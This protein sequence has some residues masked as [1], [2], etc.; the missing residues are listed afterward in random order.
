MLRYV[1]I[2]AAG[3]VQQADGQIAEPLTLK[4]LEVQPGMMM[5]AARMCGYSYVDRLE[6]NWQR[7][8]ARAPSK[9]LADQAVAAYRT[10]FDGNG[11][12][13]GEKRARI[14]SEPEALQFRGVEDWR[15][16]LE[17]WRW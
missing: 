10:G 4:G 2:V 16:M 6:Q 15:H 5:G 17:N 12:Y 9:E 3:L 8:L 14:C 1:V 11:F 13:T 7:F